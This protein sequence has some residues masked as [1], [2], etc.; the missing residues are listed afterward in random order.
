MGDKRIMHNIT[1]FDSVGARHA[2]Y[3][4]ELERLA[5]EVED[6]LGVL[7]DADPKGVA[8]V[9]TKLRESLSRIYS[10]GVLPE[11]SADLS[12]KEP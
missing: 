6:L 12:R 8:Y 7:D 2:S 10:A 11:P 3:Q 9:A 4:R 1:R 5:T